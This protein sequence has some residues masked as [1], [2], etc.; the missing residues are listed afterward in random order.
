MEA[1]PVSPLDFFGEGSGEGRTATKYVFDCPACP[2]LYR[3]E[4]VVAWGRFL[5]FKTG[6]LTC[7]C[8][9]SIGKTCIRDSSLP[10]KKSERVR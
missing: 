4:A 5:Y 7:S 3:G 6:G 9:V 1:D 10:L 8:I 2:P